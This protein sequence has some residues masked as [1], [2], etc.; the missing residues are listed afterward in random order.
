MKRSTAWFPVFLLVLLGCGGCFRSLERTT[1]PATC[2]GGGRCGLGEADRYSPRWPVATAVAGA[3]LLGV[4]GVMVHTG[5]SQIEEL[6]QD[7]DANVSQQ[8]TR[9]FDWDASRDDRPVFLQNVGSGLIGAGVIALVTAAMMYF[10]QKK[11][12][13]VVIPALESGSPV[14]SPR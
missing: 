11:P 1:C 6:E 12:V 9:P 5:R 7:I 4:G 2:G 10:H 13:L 14:T 3:L 8:G